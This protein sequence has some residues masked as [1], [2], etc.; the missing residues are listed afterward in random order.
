MSTLN[1]SPLPRPSVRS[2]N[3]PKPYG[4]RYFAAFLV[5]ALG[6]FVLVCAALANG[7]DQT[8]S[9]T[10]EVQPAADF[11][12]LSRRLESPLYWP[13]WFYSLQKAVII[14]SS[15]QP[16]PVSEQTTRA[17]AM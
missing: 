12:T 6:A 9:F 5:T 4:W 17:G 11:K 15:G 8:L 10:R 2:V 14:D 7:P 1:P 13:E 16:L 3:S